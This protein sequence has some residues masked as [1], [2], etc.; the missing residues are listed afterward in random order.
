MGTEEGLYV[1]Q[2]TKDGMYIKQL[3]VKFGLHAHMFYVHSYYY[4]H[5][6]AKKMI[7]N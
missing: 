4:P 7:L 1:A 6:L 5:L 2:L 3:T